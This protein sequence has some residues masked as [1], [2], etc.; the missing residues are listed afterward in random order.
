MRL[1]TVV[2]AAVWLGVLT[3]VLVAAE[4]GTDAARGFGFGGPMVGLVGLDLALVNPVLEAGGYGPLA[5]EV[6]TWGGGGGGGHV[7]GLSFGGSGWGG[8]ATSLVGE[9]SAEL[10]FGF[11]GVD[12]A[13]TVSGK[14]DSLLSLGLVAGGGALDL[15]LRE[16]VPESF[17][18]AVAH[19]TTTSL[20][21]G[22]FGLEPY[23][24]FNVQL[25][26]WLG[27][28]LQL[29]YLFAFPGAW[30]EGGAEIP[31]P[32][33][34]L[35]TP[36]IGVALAFGGSGPVEPAPEKTIEDVLDSLF[37]DEEF[38]NTACSALGSFYEGHCGPIGPGAEALA[39]EALV[40]KVFLAL[41]AWELPTLEPLL[42][43]DVSWVAPE[44]FLPWGGT[45]VGKPAFL[46]AVRGG[47][48]ILGAVQ[49]DGILSEGDEV[50]IKWHRM[51]G[52]EGGPIAY[53]V[54][55]CRTAEGKILSGR[56]YR[57]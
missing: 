29:G 6:V 37:E 31:G 39:N 17:D 45:W 27:L 24:R 51:P 50:V 10:S 12:L 26:P 54:T 44:G 52:P 49:I 33:A 15:S 5:G 19:P 47:P 48:V 13:Y 11:G 3:G 1:R 14:G 40:E 7:G 16:R 41:H 2:V 53:G 35:S 57:N 42:T 18:D 28:K 34:P 25:L 46:A 20:S 55:V 56:D 22:F 36:Y 38:R 23:V 21:R 9:K 4:G 30:A 32:E 8:T 43:D